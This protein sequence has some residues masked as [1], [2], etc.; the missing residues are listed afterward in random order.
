MEEKREILKQHGFLE[1]NGYWVRDD[2]CIVG[3]L[4]S[5]SAPNFI[6]AFLDATERRS[7]RRTNG[8]LS[9]EVSGLSK[10]ADDFEE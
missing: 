8:S 6:R 1:C 10:E 2:V 9:T 7:V 3:E 5:E 4:I